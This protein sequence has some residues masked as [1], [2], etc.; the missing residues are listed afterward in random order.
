[1]WTRPAQWYELPAN[2][3][4]L[5][6]LNRRRSLSQWRPQP[7]QGVKMANV[8]NRA[9]DIY[10]DR[11]SQARGFYTGPAWGDVE[12][13]LGAQLPRNPVAARQTIAAAI[14]P[15]G[16][17][18]PT[19]YDSLSAIEAAA[20]AA[21]NN[22][23]IAFL[24]GVDVNGVDLGVRIATCDGVSWRTSPISFGVPN[25]AAPIATDLAQL[26][27]P[28]A[29]V[30]RQGDLCAIKSGVGDDPD[31]NLVYFSNRDPQRSD[32]AQATAA[33]GDAGWFPQ[34]PAGAAVANIDL[35]SRLSNGGNPYYANKTRDGAF[36]T[37]LDGAQLGNNTPFGWSVVSGT[38][39]VDFTVTYDAVA[40]RYDVTKLTANPIRFESVTARPNVDPSFNARETQWS[41]FEQLEVSNQQADTVVRLTSV[42]N[43]TF[44]G[45]E[46]RLVLQLDVAADGD[47]WRG[48]GTGSVGALSGLSASVARTFDMSPND[49]G[50]GRIWGNGLAEAVP[51]VSVSFIG[52][53]GAPVTTAFFAEFE[54]AAGAVWSF[55]RCGNIVVD[56]RD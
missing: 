41:K 50:V 9:S 8:S 47:D 2:R 39:G 29:G 49:T 35:I 44:L 14:N 13:A 33:R 53:E 1:M 55:G 34:P 6:F 4:A 40:G 15:N 16:L 20:P 32:T 11:L 12:D 7:H 30:F 10:I 48:L 17:I 45:G 5:P 37:P 51:D 25:Q 42:Y 52:T 27:D 54:G 18:G 56:A 46:Q 28:A 36:V 19:V 43:N 22:G 38:P 26:L 21:T 24:G 3:D 23:A 31:A